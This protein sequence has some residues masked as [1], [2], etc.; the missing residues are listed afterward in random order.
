[1]LTLARNFHG[2]VRYK[3]SIFVCLTIRQR[4]FMVRQD[5]WCC[6]PRNNWTKSKRHIST[7][8]RR[9]TNVLLNGQ[10]SLWGSEDK[11]LARTGTSLTATRVCSAHALMA[12]Q[13]NSELC[14]CSEGNTSVNIIGGCPIRQL[15][16]FSLVNSFKQTGQINSH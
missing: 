12:R 11:M 9:W 2:V 5:K 7:A 1:M 8:I 16:Y 4:G 6:E 13:T 3:R 15:Q 14:S 10:P